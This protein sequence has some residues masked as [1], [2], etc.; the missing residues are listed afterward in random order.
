MK[1]ILVI[2]FVANLL[3]FVLLSVGPFSVTEGQMR[4]YGGFFLMIFVC[5]H[6]WYRYGLNRIVLFFCMAGSRS[7]ISPIPISSVKKSVWFLS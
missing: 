4:L 5:T 2:S 1:Q 7:A 6:G 3:V